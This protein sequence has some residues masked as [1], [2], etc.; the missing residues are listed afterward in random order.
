MNNII[1]YNS[2]KGVY[3][4]TSFGSLL[5]QTNTSCFNSLASGPD[6][7]IYAAS[8]DTYLYAYE[9]LTGSL[10]WKWTNSTRLE[11]SPS[12]DYDGTIYIG[13]EVLY[14]IH[15]SGSKMWE[16]DIHGRST[17]IYNPQLAL[18]FASSPSIGANGMVYVGSNDGYLYAI[19]GPLIPTN[20]PTISPSFQVDTKSFTSDSMNILLIIYIIVPVVVVILLILLA[21]SF[22]AYQYNRNIDKNII[23]ENNTNKSSDGSDSSTH[24]VDE[25]KKYSKFSMRL[26]NNH[27]KTSVLALKKSHNNRDISLSNSTQL[28]TIHW[29]DLV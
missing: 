16:F 6:G 20:N 13:S 24:S 25:T 27:Y 28:S 1:Y 23:N 9:P 18:V 7:T 17:S 3:A 21:F 10:K 19:S 11:N 14:A 29:N 4:V 22:F 15:P 8:Q 5:W 2:L 26:F 12:V